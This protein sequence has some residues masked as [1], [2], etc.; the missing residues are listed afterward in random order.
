M[1]ASCAILPPVCCPVGH[2]AQLRLPVSPA[3]R[4]G[5]HD[6]HT[7]T[8]LCP[9]AVNTL[10]SGLYLPGSHERHTFAVVP[11]PVTSQ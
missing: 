11:V 3:N 2:T 5:A 6:A 7:V 4:P 10:A 1:H 9:S 8:E